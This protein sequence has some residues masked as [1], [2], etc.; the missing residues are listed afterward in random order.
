MISILLVKKLFELFLIMIMGFTLVKLKVLNSK[1]SKSISIISLYLIT[2][3]VIINAFQ[4][5][6]TVEKRNGLLLA[7]LAAIIIHII[8][9]SLTKVFHKF[10]KLDEVER[11]SIIY[12]N[13]GNLIIPLVASILGPEWVIY[14][15][16]FVSVQLVIMWTHGK[17]LL[18][19]ENKINIRNITT[20]I[21]FISV[22]VGMIFFVNQVRL[23]EVIRDTLGSVGG[24]IGPISMIITGM[25]IGN[26]N[27]K[28]LLS[29]KK[30]YIVAFLKMIFY[31]LVALVFLKFGGLNSLV[32][33]GKTILLITLLATITPSA[34]TITQMSQIYGRDAEYA[35]IINV[36]TT[37][38]CIITMPLIVLIYQL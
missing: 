25:L 20:N 24:T 30:I 28:K 3:C 27:L 10:L 8:L 2:P 35:S 36:I 38:I 33:E 31:P 16:A 1:D 18:S 22:I 29:Y 11:G 15:S 14:S 5:Q 26:V 23:P 32:P 6:Y 13:S 9:L 17:M 21:N 12:S 7:F 4:V 19:S 34:S 37:L